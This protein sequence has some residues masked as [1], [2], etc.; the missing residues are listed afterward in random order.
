M[1]GRIEE[2]MDIRTDGRNEWVKDSRMMDV[3]NERRNGRTEV[4]KPGSTAGKKG[5]RK[6]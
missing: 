1:D 2:R 6:E 3:R 5:G 4:R